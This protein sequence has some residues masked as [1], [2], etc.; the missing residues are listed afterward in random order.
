MTMRDLV[1]KLFGTDNLDEEVKL[2]DQ[3][4]QSEPTG[5]GNQEQQNTNNDTNNQNQNQPNSQN[6]QLNNVSDANQEE[7]EDMNIFELGWYDEKTG[8][9]NLKKIKNEE[10]RGVIEALTTRHTQ[11]MQARDI[12]DAITSELGNYQLNVSTD[13][14]KKMLDTSGIKFDDTGKIVGIKDAIENVKKAEPGLFK[15]KAKETTPFQEPFNPNEN[16]PTSLSGITSFEQAILAARASN[17]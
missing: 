17:Q 12:Q 15:D 2:E 6:N 13:T 10:V 1:K 14:L 9:I 3:E 11:E 8:K 16:T 4:S 7:V 5:K